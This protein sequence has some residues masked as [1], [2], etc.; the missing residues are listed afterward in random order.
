M[1]KIGRSYLIIG[2]LALI[3]LLIFEYNTPKQINWYPSYV[4]THKIPFG[5][6]VLNDLLPGLFE[7]T[8]QVYRS[9]Y[10]FLS[11]N[12]S[13]KGS[14]VFVNNAIAFGKTDLDQLLNWVSEG[15]HLFLAAESFEDQLL[16]TLKLSTSS[17]YDNN[18]V[19]PI[20]KHRLTN[21]LLLSK[22]AVYTKDY[23]SAVFRE[24]DTLTTVILGEVHTKSDSLNVETRGSNIV[25]MPFGNGK[26]TCSLFPE[27]FTNYFLLKEDN[28]RY[29][30]GLM[31]YLDGNE[32]IYLDNHHK[33][34]K[35]FYTSRMYLFLNTKEFKWAYYLVLIGALMYIIFEGKRKQRAIRVIPPLKNQTLAFTKT[36]ADMYFENNKQQEIAEHKIQYFLDF[37]RTTFYMSTENIDAQFYQNLGLRSNHSKE[38]IVK[39]FKLFHNIQNSSTV[40]SAQ[41]QELEA[42][43]QKF[44]EK[45]DGKQ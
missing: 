14:Y 16:D 9:P 17:I 5:T 1:I 4:A 21:P 2:G 45:A 33:A 23:Y 19:D 6:K 43:I 40:T 36:I 24:I 41:L 31:S 18:V 42:E 22:T 7:N 29:T 30:S 26:I 11:K 34:G 10:E 13:V 38:E 20:Y 28:Y 3:A 8:Q 39:L 37:I 27:A 12:D 35:T 32:T 25:Q 44:K 15:N